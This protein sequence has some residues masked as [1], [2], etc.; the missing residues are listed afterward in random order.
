MELKNNLNENLFYNHINHPV[1]NDLLKNE[2]DLAWHYGREKQTTYSIVPGEH[3]PNDDGTVKYIYNSEYFRSEEFTK[4]HN[5][6]HVLFSGCSESEGIGG[7]IED[8]WNHML[9]NKLLQK[10]KCSGF[11][12]LSRA[13]WGWNRIILNCLTYF[14]KYGCPDILFILLPNAQRKFEYSEI[15]FLDDN[16]EP[17]GHWKYVQKYLSSKPIENLERAHS[18][19]KEYNEDFVNFLI[20][21]KMFNKIC[22]DNDVKLFFSTWDPNDYKYFKHINLFDNFCFIRENEDEYMKK[23]Y[24]LNKPKKTDINKR[25]GHNGVLAHYSWA[26]HFYKN[27]EESL[28]D[29]NI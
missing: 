27:Y 7:N 5:G 13:G 17:I 21:W 9:Y 8:S 1:F 2:F 18:G 4:N 20:A 29:K 22:K 24:L 6:L 28:N 10:N 16:G 12:N 3:K 23:Y 25:D 19:I 15:N 26:E 14:N 11:F